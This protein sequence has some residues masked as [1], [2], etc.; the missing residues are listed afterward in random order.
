MCCVWCD[1]NI[2]SSIR[3]RSWLL[4]AAPLR[5][6]FFSWGTWGHSCSTRQD[7]TSLLEPFAMQTFLLNPPCCNQVN[8]SDPLKAADMLLKMASLYSEEPETKT[9]VFEI[10]G[11]WNGAKPWISHQLLLF[12]Q[13][14]LLW[15]TWLWMFCALFPTR[16]FA[17]EAPLSFMLPFIPLPLHSDGRD[18]TPEGRAWGWKPLFNISVVHPGE[19]GDLGGVKYRGWWEIPS[20]D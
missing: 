4:S 9:A 7:M 5:R 2:L 6:S 11:K 13:N 16:R 15:V 18:G 19:N 1:R 8:P 3:Q 12:F 20:F 14:L 17:D 10:V